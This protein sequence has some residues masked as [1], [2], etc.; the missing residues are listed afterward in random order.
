MTVSR[1]Q[2]IGVGVRRVLLITLG[3]NVL[4]CVGKIVVGTI[5]GSLAMVA[6]GY[7]SLADGG[8]NIIGLVVTAFA[9]APPDRGHPYGHRKFETAATT[10]IGAALLLLAY[11]LLSSVVGPGAHHE[12]PQ[13][14][15]LTWS[16]MLCTLAIN[17]GVTWYEAR[18][19]RRLGSDFL[20]ADSTH[21]R[22]DIY[23]SLGV[24]ASFVAV[25]A[26]LA[27]A[28]AGVALVIAGL[29]A[30]QAVKILIGA[31]NVLTDRAALAPE[32]ISAVLSGM[33]EI[34]Q[35]RDIRTRGGRGAVY[36]DLVVHVDGGLTLRMAHEVADRIEQT[37]KAGLPEVVDVMVHLEPA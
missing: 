20:I 32:R 7:H 9:Y 2:A 4:V 37:V 17:F 35:L 26:G 15:A 1:D 24:I 11:E 31:F 30:Y 3:L 13:I 18:E 25:R 6:D 8:N 16:V 5:A 27:F 10:A 14:G 21:T 22:A 23:V 29:I 12:P 19:G 28:D 33:G 36:V 34:R